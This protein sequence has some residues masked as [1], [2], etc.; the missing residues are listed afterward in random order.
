MVG[1]LDH[2][3]VSSHEYRQ[4]KLAR[5]ALDC[6]EGRGPLPRLVEIGLLCEAYQ[7]SP[8]ELGFEAN[9]RTI[10]D[11]RVS[12]AVYNAVKSRQDAKDKR[13]WDNA[14][15]SLVDLIRWAR[16]GETNKPAPSEVKIEVPERPKDWNKTT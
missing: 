12:T 5:A 9:P 1:G 4:P 11:I 8:M 10:R 3:V 6:A 14:N 16:G 2:G 13:E 15:K 7:C